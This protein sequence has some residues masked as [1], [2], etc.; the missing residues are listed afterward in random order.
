MPKLAQVMLYAETF[1]CSS[2][3]HPSE[4]KNNAS[5]SPA[6][7]GKCVNSRGRRKTDHRDHTC[8]PTGCQMIYLQL[9]E[10]QMEPNPKSSKPN[11]TTLHVRWDHLVAVTAPQYWAKITGW[12]SKSNW[13]S[14]GTQD[15]HCNIILNLKLD[16][17]N[18]HDVKSRKP[19]AAQVRFF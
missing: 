4:K 6:T 15:I 10:V 18:R 16:D 8:H 11:T 17:R 19:C 5:K 9:Q 13:T 12:D 1:H 7:E 2:Y 14:S 3:S